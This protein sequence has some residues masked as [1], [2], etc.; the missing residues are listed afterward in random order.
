[1]PKFAHVIIYSY[2]CVYIYNVYVRMNI[3]LY[4]YICNYLHI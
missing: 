3:S 1:M 4:D 2:V